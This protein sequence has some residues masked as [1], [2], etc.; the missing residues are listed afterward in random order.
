[1]VN[2]AT[3][4]KCVVLWESISLLLLR[5]ISLLGRDLTIIGGEAGQAFG[6]ALILSIT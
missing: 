1:M 3:C 4:V 5:S 2:K 6:L